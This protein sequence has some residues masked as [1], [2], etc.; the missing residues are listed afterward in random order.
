MKRSTLAVSTFAIS[1]VALGGTGCATKKFV[2]TTVSPVE[3]RVGQV[4][5]KTTD[6]GTAIEGLEADLSKTKERIGDVDSR[7]K[8]TNAALQETEGKVGQA[9]S[10][11]DKAQQSAGEARTYAENRSNNLEK[12]VEGRDTFKLATTE[13]VLF[14]FGRADLDTDA[15]AALDEIAKQLGQKKRFI[16]EVQGFT[17]KTGPTNLNLSLS[18]RRAETVVRYLTSQ[19][20]IPLRSIHLIGSGV[21]QAEQKTREERKQSRRVEIRLFAPEMEN[22]SALTSAQLR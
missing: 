2:R 14:K 16:I 17:D 10:A 7:L 19:H 9:Q 11:A 18:Q 4:E 5:K 12:Y 3:Q 22:P 13:N 6:Q 8:Q 1:L 21:D 15:K 20:N